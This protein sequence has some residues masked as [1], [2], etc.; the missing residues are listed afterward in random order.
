MWAING[1]FFLNECAVYVHLMDWVGPRD[2]LD[3]FKKKKK[4]LLFL[5][6]IEPRFFDR[7]AFSLVTLLSYTDLSLVS[8]VN[9]HLRS[10][11]Q[12]LQSCQSSSISHVL[13]L[14]RGLYLWPARGRVWG[15]LVNVKMNKYVFR[16]RI[17]GH[18]LSQ[19]ACADSYCQR[20][21]DGVSR[22]MMNVTCA[23]FHP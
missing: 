19:M 5:L 13:S 8:T 23:Y 1:R 9:I 18:C 21:T 16:W 22:Q 4:I 6:G 2:S 12:S 3:T 7:P 17:C 11:I 20:L 10:L 15:K 14:R